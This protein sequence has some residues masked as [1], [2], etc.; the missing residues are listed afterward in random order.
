MNLYLEQIAKWLETKI[1]TKQQ[2]IHTG[3]RKDITF[4]DYDSRLL[5]KNTNMTL[6]AGAD[7]DAYRITWSGHNG[8]RVNDLNVNG[9]RSEKVHVILWTDSE[10]FKDERGYF[11]DSEGDLNG[12]LVVSDLEIP[13][14]LSAIHE[15]LNIDIGEP[16]KESDTAIANATDRIQVLMDEVYNEWQKADNKGKWEVLEGFSEAHKI[17]VAFG[18]FN[19]QVENG[20]IEQWIYN[21]YFHDD[22]EKFI[23]YLETGA[24]TDERCKAILD[25]VSQ[26]EQYANETGSD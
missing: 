16:V 18:N 5:G 9:N 10:V 12:V 8:L 21:G 2:I 26:L 6:I 11:L 20:G 14:D 19:Y 17:A 25:R 23:E 1:G 24:Q 4:V 3:E 13:I 15:M 22:S 7:L